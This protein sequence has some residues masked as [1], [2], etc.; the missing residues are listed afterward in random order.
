VIDKTLLLVAWEEWEIDD[1]DDDG[2]EDLAIFKLADEVTEE[3][4]QQMREAVE[5]EDDDKSD[6]LEK[7]WKSMRLH[8][9]NAAQITRGIQYRGINDWKRFKDCFNEHGVF[10][11]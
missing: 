3:E 1:G 11:A 7:G 10:R 9:A 2:E 4:V 8:F 5:K 6:D